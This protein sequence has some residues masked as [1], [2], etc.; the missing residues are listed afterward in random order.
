MHRFLKT[1]RKFCKKKRKADIDEI[2]KL[3]SG[4]LSYI[5]RLEKEE[6]IEKRFIL[7]II[8]KIKEL[9]LHKEFNISVAE[10]YKIIKEKY[11]EGHFYYLFLEEIQQFKQKID[12]LKELLEKQR[13]KYDIKL[14]DAE[15]EKYNELEGLFDKIDYSESR[16]R[17][18]FEDMKHLRYKRKYIKSGQ[19]ISKII[20]GVLLRV[21]VKGIENIPKKGPCILAPHHHHAAFDPLILMALINRPLF[22]LA[23]VET[24]LPGMPIYGRIIHNIGAQPFKRDDS[25]YGERLPGAIKKEK[26]DSFP[27]SN[28]QSIKNMLIHLKHGDVIVIFPEGD[29]KEMLTYA[30]KHNENFIK[31]SEGFVGLAVMAKIKFGIDVPIVPIGISY[32]PGILKTGGTSIVRNILG[33]I[34]RMVKVRIGKPVYLPAN[35]QKLNKKQLKKEITRY[36]KYIFDIIKQLSQ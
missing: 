10:F 18:Y 31:P 11:I 14:F 12:E 7:K 20:K 21:Q 4:Q 24:F 26:V 28:L 1:L 27:S 15:E 19:I 30:R 13:A 22:F 17:E 9:E 32:G 33:S 36:T 8:D 5:D 34:Q 29:A 35:L 16:I 23:S 2:S 3:I 25:S 6:E